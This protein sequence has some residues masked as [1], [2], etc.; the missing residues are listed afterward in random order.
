MSGRND[1]NLTPIG[2]FVRDLDMLADIGIEIDDQDG[3]FIDPDDAGIPYPGNA[4]LGNDDLRPESK[5]RTGRP[6]TDEP[7]PLD[8]IAADTAYAA[9]LETMARRRS[10]GSPANPPGP[11][12]GR[13]RPSTPIDAP[14]APA[15]PT[16]HPPGIVDAPRP[17]AHGPDPRSPHRP[18]E[19]DL[20]SAP[21]RDSI[22]KRLRA[23]GL[24]AARYIG[25]IT[26]D[27]PKNNWSDEQIARIRATM[28]TPSGWRGGR[29]ATKSPLRLV[30]QQ[31]RSNK[32]P[33][34]FNQTAFEA[35]V[36]GIKFDR[37]G[38]MIL[39]L[40]IDEKD[41]IDAALLLRR[42]Y[43]T[44]FLVDINRIYNVHN[45]DEE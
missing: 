21:D 9:R 44:R 20:R 10:V 33:D 8:A 24:T 14:S 26:T 23:I 18:D 11:P 15:R 45:E 6:N 31:A 43:G 25:V 1:D 17:V 29:Q 38:N 34:D 30:A 5:L 35:T 42:A 2:G 3:N 4:A 41:D 28:S 16:G 27:S 13:S 19:S 39:T 32:L 7:E 37:A 22:V 40:N 36:S 12:G